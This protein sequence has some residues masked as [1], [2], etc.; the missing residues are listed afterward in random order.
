MAQTPL[1]KKLHLLRYLAFLS[2]PSARRRYFF[3]EPVGEPNLDFT[4]PVVCTVVMFA[5]SHLIAGT[6]DDRHWIH[7]IRRSSG[8]LRMTKPAM[9]RF[10]LFSIGLLVYCSLGCYF[11]LPWM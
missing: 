10:W 7:A 2:S 9:V 4:H 6:D 1:R 3:Q 11:F 5:L 8:L